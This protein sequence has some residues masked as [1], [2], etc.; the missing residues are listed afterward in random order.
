MPLTRAEKAAARRATF[1]HGGNAWARKHKN[2]KIFD[3]LKGRR[4]S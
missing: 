1:F 2:G 3:R 4:V